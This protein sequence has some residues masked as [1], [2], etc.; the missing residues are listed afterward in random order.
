LPLQTWLI[1]LGVIALLIITPGPSA[2]LCLAHGIQHG[3]LRTIAT[4]FGGTCASMILMSASAL[5]L[6]AIIATSE[7]AFHV[8]KLLGA[9]YLI[10]LGITTWRG[11]ENA[12]SGQTVES[13]TP[14][15]AKPI[16]ILFRNGFMVGISNPK[17][18]IFFGAL[19]PHFIDPAQAQAM[20]FA[21]LALT[22]TVLDAVIMLGYAMLGN[23]IAPWIFHRGKARVFQ[24]VSGGM[25]IVAGGALAAAQ[26]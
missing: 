5:G 22:W 21:I 18:L 3:K 15:A 14:S 12:P 26:K 11:R 4:V 20:Q 7:I 6:G 16:R 1:Y 8:I 19:F 17:D 10:Y 24:R 13:G 23:K 25:F 9:A 2:M